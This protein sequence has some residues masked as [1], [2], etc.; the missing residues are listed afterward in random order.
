MARIVIIGAGLTGLSAAYHLEKK[1]FFDY[2]MYEKEATIGGLCRSV[3]QDGFTFD[4]T[5]HL[6]HT[7]DSYF[8]ELI[9]TLVGFDHLNAITRR[10]YIYSQQTYTKYPFQVNL[11]GLPIATIVECIEEYVKRP[12]KRAHPTMFKEWVQHSFGQGFGKYFFYPYQ[13]KIFACNLNTLTADWTG[14]FVPNTSLAQII[15]GALQEP[16]EA[17]GYNAQFFYP[18]KGGIIA[19]VQKIADALQNPIHTNHTVTRINT[20]QSTVTFSN[21]HSEPY[22]QLITTMPLDRLLAVVDEPAHLSVTRAGKHLKCNSVINFN[23]GIAR[24]DL[25]QKHWI[26]F[27]EKQFPFYRLGFP[28]NFSAN[29]APEG[30]SSLYGEFAHLNKSSSWVNTTL[31]HSLAATKTLLNIGQTDILTEKVMHIP[32]AYVIYDRWRQKNLPTLLKRLSH[33]N[34]YSVGRYGEWKYSSMQEAVLDG[35]KIAEQLLIQPA[36]KSWIAPE[37]GMPSSRSQQTT[38]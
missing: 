4:F 5:G 19:W 18:K 12:H 27:P 21:G 10:S 28:H 14:R 16:A 8:K 37:V 9:D 32:H 15:Q 6:L 11:F 13:Q 24:N 34:I 36:I 17:L 31:K 30:C 35:K 25:S 38:I 7:N 1:G 20:K 26:Y 2:A 23:L 33:E 29:M 3:Q 22:D